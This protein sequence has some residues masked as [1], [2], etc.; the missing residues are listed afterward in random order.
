MLVRFEWSALVNSGAMDLNPA[1]VSD[2]PTILPGLSLCINAGACLNRHIIA[3]FTSTLNMCWLV[4]IA[5]DTA[6]LEGDE[7]TFLVPL[8]R[9]VAYL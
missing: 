5:Q 7:R 2:F 8:H 1:Q 3:L 6:G 4:A 9:W